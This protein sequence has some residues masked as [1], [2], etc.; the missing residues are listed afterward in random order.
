MKYFLNED[1]RKES[2]STCYHE[3]AKGEWNEEACVFW[4]K[5]SMNIHDDLLISLK[6]DTLFSSIVE[7]YS[8]T[9]ETKINKKQWRKIYVK[10][11][12][13]CGYLLDAI[14]EVTPWVEANFRQYEVFTILGV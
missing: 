5:D 4:Q 3:F 11:E 7:D 2:N 9:G 8:P 1:E 6:L 13:I 14:L 10:A 12:E